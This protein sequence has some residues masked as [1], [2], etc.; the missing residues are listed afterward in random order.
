MRKLENYSSHGAGSK[1]FPKI[2]EQALLALEINELL[3]DAYMVI[4]HGTAD[5]Q[6]VILNKLQ[7]HFDKTG[8]PEKA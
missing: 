1:S 6:V 2:K 7:S 3:W 5:E 8:R 4:D